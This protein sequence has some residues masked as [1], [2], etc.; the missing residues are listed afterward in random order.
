MTSDR[1][2][3]QP[4]LAFLSGLVIVCAVTLGVGGFEPEPAP[5]PGAQPTASKSSPATRVDREA[6][7]TT[8]RTLSAPALRGRATG[9]PGGRLARALIEDAFA[10]AGLTP[11]GT[12]G[13]LQPFSFTDEGRTYDDAANVVGRAAGN[14]EATRPIVVSAH[15]DH[16]GV[17]DGRVY[18]G[19]DDN[20]SGVAVLVAVARHFVRHRPRH[21]MIVV[22]FDAEEQGLHGARHFLASWPSDA[23]LPVLNVNLDMVSRSDRRELFV[24][25]TSYSPWLREILADVRRRSAVTLR[26]GHDVPAPDD[27]GRDDWTTLSDHGV[28]HER[29]IPFLYFGVEDHADYHQPTDTADRI[30]AA[31]FGDAAD[32]I[33][34]SLLAVDARMAR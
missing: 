29:G 1:R 26:F 3:R 18:P 30:D 34:E 32:T 15:Y 12:R 28:F 21:P 23:P 13:F 31:F 24:A 27:D 8:V 9:T 16:L 19:A 33:L 14:G 10:A 6:L 25:G 17:K 22:V 2:C 20:A 11:A 4:A 7:L 5:H